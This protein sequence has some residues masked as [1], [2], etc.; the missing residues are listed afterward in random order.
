MES[1]R[2]SNSELEKKAEG[3]L[4]AMKNGKEEQARM[5]ELLRSELAQQVPGRSSL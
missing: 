4:V 5:E 3:Y 2:E 1:L